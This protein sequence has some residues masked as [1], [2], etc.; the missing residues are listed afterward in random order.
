MQRITPFIEPEGHLLPIDFKNLPFEPKRIFIVSGVPALTTRGLHA[1]R[2]TRQ[3]LIGLAGVVIVTLETATETKVHILREGTVVEIPPLTWS[4]QE[5]LTD[6]TV[7][8]SI[9]ST[10]YDPADYIFDKK[11]LEEIWK[12][13]S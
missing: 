13:P 9:C 2:E 7:M 4:S 8:L 1:H 5:Y 3:L 10:Y 11:E 6:K 12:R